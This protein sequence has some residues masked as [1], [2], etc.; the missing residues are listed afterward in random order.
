MSIQSRRQAA[1]ANGG[2][3]RSRRQ[4]FRHRP[5]AIGKNDLDGDKIMEREAKAVF[6]KRFVG[7]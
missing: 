6:R 5:A 4:S 7:V 2:A 3:W 1:R